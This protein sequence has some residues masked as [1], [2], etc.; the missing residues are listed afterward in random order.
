MRVVFMGSAP[1]A[2]PTLEFLSERHD[3]VGVVTQPDKPQGRKRELTPT[4]VKQAALRLGKPVLEPRKLKAPD[5]LDA[6]RG[7]APEVI[8]VFAY[9]RRVPSEVLYMPPHGCINIHGSILP[10]Y[11]GACPIE[12]GIMAGDA[13]TGIT[14]FYMA[15]GFDTGDII[16]TEAMPIGPDDTGGTLRGKLSRLGAEVIGKTL[17]AVARGDAPRIGQDHAQATHAPVITRD[18]ARV[19]WTRSAREIDCQVRAC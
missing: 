6:L 17:D 9:G 13:E 5:F 4:A 18:E 19:D 12:R 10:K 11:R 8:V 3:V 7:T 2:V 16:L 14:T 1:I 15:E